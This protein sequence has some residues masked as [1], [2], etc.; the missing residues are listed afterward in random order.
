MLARVAHEVAQE[1][2]LGQP[3]VLEGVGRE[4]PV[5]AHQEGRLARLG[6][7]TRD[8]RQVRG[9]LR[10]AREQDPPARVRDGHDIVVAG[11]DV[12]CLAGQ[13]TRA[14]VEHHRRRLPLMTWRTS[15]MSTRP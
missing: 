8:G 14:D 11:V 7:P 13:G 1:V 15:F 4:E 9:L 2:V 6:D 10:V 3:H 5:L 12:E